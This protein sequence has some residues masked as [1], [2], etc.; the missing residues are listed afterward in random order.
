MPAMNVSNTYPTHMLP[1]DIVSN[2]QR[3]SNYEY[4]ILVCVKSAESGVFWVLVNYIMTLE[5]SQTIQ[6]RVLGWLVKDNM[7]S[8]GNAAIDVLS[9]DIYIF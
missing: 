3:P 4:S 9:I 7:Q 6:R 5:V 1:S 8:I 2:K